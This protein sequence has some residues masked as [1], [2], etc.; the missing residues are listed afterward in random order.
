MLPL[1]SQA[2]TFNSVNLTLLDPARASHAA[3]AQRTAM[4]T[5]IAAFLCPSGLPPPVDDF[6]RVNFRFCFGPSSFPFCFH[7]TPGDGTSL[8]SSGAFQI[9]GYWSV[10]TA[11]ITDGLSH[12]NGGRSG[13]REIGSSPPTSPVVTR[14][15]S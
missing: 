4:A 1:L 10:R 9:A 3:F 6:G 15:S 8:A 11:S 2:A 13:C 14:G 12:I 5:S 7:K